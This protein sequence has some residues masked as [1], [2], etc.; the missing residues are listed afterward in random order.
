VT[1]GDS[2]G[3]S[4]PSFRYGRTTARWLHMLES[5]GMAIT[6]RERLVAR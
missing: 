5:V 2:H 4:V 1:I 6:Q 3:V